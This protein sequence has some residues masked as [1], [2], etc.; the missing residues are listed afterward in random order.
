MISN[1]SIAISTPKTI[2]KAN[3]IVKLNYHLFIIIAEQYMKI[4]PLTMSALQDPSGQSGVGTEV[5]R[6]MVNSHKNPVLCIKWLPSS[7]EFDRKYIYNLITPI[8]PDVHHQF[9]SISEDGQILFW[10][11]RIGEKL[12]ARGQ[13]GK[14]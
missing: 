5:L 12:D 13:I 10:D 4:N 3:Q 7:I 9:L 11:T 2:K 6:K 8:N 1:H 14:Q